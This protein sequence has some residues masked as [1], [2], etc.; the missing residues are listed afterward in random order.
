MKHIVSLS[1]GSS[2][3]D[4]SVVE[5]L[6][7]EEFRIE[8]IGVDGDMAAYTKKL[9][10]L[11]GHVDVFGLGGTDLYVYAGSKRYTFKD[12]KRMVEPVRRTPIVDGSGLK[13]TLERE[14][15][16]HLTEN[17]IVDFKSKKTLIVSAVDRFGMAESVAACGGE[18]LYG[19]LIFGIGIDVPIRSFGALKAFANAV[20]PVIVNLP[21]QWFY[22]TGEKQN[23]VE[24]KW[25]Q[26]YAWADIIAGDF[27]LI[28]RHMP[29]DLSGKTILTNTTTA[30][31]VEELRKR[32][33][34]MLITTTPEFEGRTFGTNV[35]EAVLVALSGKQ[36]SEL[37]PEDYL[38]RLKALGWKPRVQRLQEAASAT[39]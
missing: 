32:G 35:M 1:L 12:I 13:N 37:K 38:E 39:A 22:P 24:P 18:V 5:S 7:G 26:H 19:D 4:K 28:R 8:R 14:T 29:D 33:V 36:A 25:G 23:V 3:R 21:F 15:V 10:E 16:T 2:R 9:I 11:D 34:S 20:L 31:D 6:L 17:G 27:L 30:E